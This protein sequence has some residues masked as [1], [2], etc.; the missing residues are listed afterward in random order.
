MAFAFAGPLVVQI[1]PEAA[2]IAAR[3]GHYAATR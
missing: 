2:G 3:L 1:A